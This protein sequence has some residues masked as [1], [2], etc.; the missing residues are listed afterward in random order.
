MHIT[1]TDRAAA[2]IEKK[3]A[4]FR[5]RNRLPRILLAAQTCHGAEFR[6]FWDF[7]KE[8]D[9]CLHYGKLSF[10]VSPELLETYGG[11]D[12]DIES[13]FFTTRLLVKPINDLKQCDCGKSRPCGEKI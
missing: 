11:F 12:L 3:H 4:F 1:I 5:S 2:W 6:L 13:F 9:V 7:Q 8:T 10:L